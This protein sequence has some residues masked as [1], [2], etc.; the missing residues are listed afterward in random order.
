MSRFST[1]ILSALWIVGTILTLIQLYASSDG[2]QYPFTASLYYLGTSLIMTFIVIKFRDEVSKKAVIM[3]N[4]II[5]IFT[6]ESILL[7][8]I[9]FYSLEPQTRVE[10]LA[11]SI[12]FFAG[13]IVSSSVFFVKSKAQDS[14]TISNNYEETNTNPQAV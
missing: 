13:M 5:T 11:G 8:L 1:L 10:S 2:L 14:V 12:F 3:N 6:V 4:L 7:A 9:C